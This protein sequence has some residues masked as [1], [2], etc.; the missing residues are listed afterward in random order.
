MAVKSA[1][2]DH[3]YRMPGGL[4]CH[5]PLILGLSLTASVRASIAKANSISDG[6]QQFA[7]IPAQSTTITMSLLA[8]AKALAT[9]N[10]S[11]SYNFFLNPNFSKFTTRKSHPT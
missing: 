5:S 11:M 3:L 1:S 2:K 4:L 10:G 9:F 6:E 7:L 8:I